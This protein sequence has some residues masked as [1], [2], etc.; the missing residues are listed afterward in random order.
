MKASFTLRYMCILPCWLSCDAGKIGNAI[1]GFWGQSHLCRVT[2][3]FFLPHNTTH[4]GN[5]RS[6]S[7][8]AT[9]NS[10]IHYY[11]HIYT[12][13][14]AYKCSV[15]IYPVNELTLLHRGGLLQFFY[16]RGNGVRF[17]SGDRISADCAN[18]TS[19]RI[20]PVSNNTNKHVC[21]C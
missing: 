5:V 10:H 11:S 12:I 4:L 15:R 8:C 19:Q 14:W 7:F 3:C 1:P 9:K 18:L 13:Y 17:E 20:V 2:D 21:A 16:T 6:C